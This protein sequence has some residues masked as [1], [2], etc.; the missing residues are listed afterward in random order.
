MPAYGGVDSLTAPASHKKP[1]QAKVHYLEVDISPQGDRTKK[2]TPQE[3]WDSIPGLT[4]YRVFREDL[5][6]CLMLGRR[7]A[8][9][10]GPGDHCHTLRTHRHHTTDTTTQ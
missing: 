7:P 9:S 4:T 8:Q 5:A 6:F 2:P 10:P 1:S 3:A